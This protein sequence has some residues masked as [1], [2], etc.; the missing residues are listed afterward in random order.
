[1]RRDHHGG[2]FGGC[3]LMRSVVDFRPLPNRRA[4]NGGLA[5]HIGLEQICSQSKRGFNKYSAMNNS[6]AHLLSPDL[7]LECCMIKL[8]QKPV[9]AESLLKYRMVSQRQPSH[10][11]KPQS[12]LGVYFLSMRHKDR[13]SRQSETLAFRRACTPSTWHGG[14][15]LL[16]D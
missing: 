11:Q 4:L 2:W 5:L 15:L 9:V 6:G 8:N 14:R 1:M 16:C 7:E 10:I 3:T 13:L 12:V